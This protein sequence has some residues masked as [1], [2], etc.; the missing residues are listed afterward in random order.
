VE[1]DDKFNKA[2]YKAWL[3]SL[4]LMEP[5]DLPGM[6]IF[7]KTLTG[8][9][10]TLDVSASE[11]ATSMKAKIQDK[12]ASLSYAGKPLKNGDLTLKDYN[13]QKAT[14]LHE[15]PVLDGGAAFVKKHVPKGE[16][17][18]TLK[19][20]IC[21]GIF[22]N[23]KFSKNKVGIHNDGFQKYSDAL[24]DFKVRLESG[25]KLIEEAIEGL[26]GKTISVLEGVLAK[27]V[28]V[29]QDEKISQLAY[30]L[31]PHLDELELLEGQIETLKKDYIE[32]FVRAYIAE[33]AIEKGSNVQFDHEQFGRDVATQKKVLT[34]TRKGD[35]ASAA[36]A[37]D[38]PAKR[39]CIIS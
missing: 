4:P 9:T 16:Q 14:T 2:L 38:A 36:C 5:E 39:S 15:G 13:I 31:I 7:I 8:K 25:D 22:K 20:K 34:K 17:T 30:A 10:I 27:K 3:E 11:T 6:Q 1:Q 19:N 24:H 12:R 35:G 21:E 33:Y 26:D 32:L 37:E 29:H 18:R 28:S 23:L